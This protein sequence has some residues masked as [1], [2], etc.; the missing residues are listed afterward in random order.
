MI[1]LLA[2]SLFI[3]VYIAGGRLHVSVREL[4]NASLKEDVVPA[5]LKEGWGG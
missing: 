1:S 2:Q 5:T 4:M 3:G